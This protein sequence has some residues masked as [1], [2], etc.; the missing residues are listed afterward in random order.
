MTSTPLPLIVDAHSDLLLELAFAEHERGE[1]HPFRDRWLDPLR[2]GGVALQ[3]CAIYVGPAHLPEGGLLEALRLARAF[4]RAVDDHPEQVV[5]I[6]TAADLDRLGAGRTGLLLT[7]E[8]CDALGDEPWLIETFAQLGVRMA[9]L[10]WNRPNVYAGGC[11]VADGLTEAGARLVERMAELG[12]LVDLA[13]ASEQTFWDVLARTGPGATLV[14]HAACRALHDHPRNLTDAQLVAL[15]ERG[16]VLG[17]MAHPLVIDPRGG[18]LALFLDHVD[19][20]VETAGIEHV[21]L[22]GDFLRQI[23]RAIGSTSSPD[24]T[25]A[26]DAAID[27][28]EG[29]E[30]YPA[31][32]VALADRGYDAEQV[33]ALL[34]GNLLRLL[35][36]ALP[37]S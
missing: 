26:P 21:G 12:I 13:H 17:M 34:G 2:R 30:D 19:H 33:A 16:G 31:L 27:G 20:A 9:S 36:A 11:D 24:G 29:P 10:T 25:M 32:A 14:S 5:A 18:D 6:R 7:L 4:D 22:G 37:T 28:L 3:A 35:R 8:S 1:A 15:A 23:A